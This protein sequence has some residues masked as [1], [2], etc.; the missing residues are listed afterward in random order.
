MP[1]LSDED[2]IAAIA[3]ATGEGGIG[4]IRLSGT[5]ALNIAQRVFVGSRQFS[6]QD[7]PA[8]SLLHGRIVHPDSGSMLDEVL[9]AVMRRPHSYTREDVVEIHC[10]GGRLVL[11][12]V[13]ELVLEQGARLATPG[14]FTKRAFLNGRLDLAQ[15]ESVID[16]IQAKTDAGLQL[17]VQQ[18]QGKL[19][20]QVKHLH[21]EL[22]QLLASIE[23]SIDFADEDIELIA[24]EQILNELQAALDE[25]N[26]LLAGAQ[27]GKIVR[28]GLSV[29]IVGKPNV[30]KSSLMNVFLQEERAI[31]TPIPGTTRDTIEDY[32]NLEGVPLRLIDTAGIR[33]SDDH[34]ERLGVER[35]RQVLQQ[36][37]LILCLFDASSPWSQED[38]EFV[39]LTRDKDHVL[40][41]NKIDLPSQLFEQE[42]RA[43]F[44][45]SA[46][47][48]R[49]SVT[50]QFGLDEL[51]HALV[52]KVLALPLESVAVTNA[53]HK[54]ALQLA[55]QSL[56]HAQESTRSEMSQEFIALDIR[57]ALQHLGEISGETT[58]DD[59]L[60]RIFSTFCIGK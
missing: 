1:F 24:Y 15:A 35:S 34:L 16:I 25:L 40:I 45:D 13:L 21:D 19:S 12:N 20:S 47:F 26:Q 41:F 36:A 43:K 31:V 11:C 10:H 22:Q 5:Q 49:I 37:D 52:E 55:T 30:G 57:D 14:E 9:I 33:A 46:P 17:A 18:L 4:I 42:V 28:D 60:D 38:E 6:Q 32:I 27:E 2:T 59:L 56:N 58:T 48:F 39:E 29:A 50:R 3:T 53:R 54:Q 51:K 44:S 8:Y 23:A 7:V